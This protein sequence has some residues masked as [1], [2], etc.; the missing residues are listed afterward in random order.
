MGK[1]VELTEV[2]PDI[3]LYC[4][5]EHVVCLKEDGRRELWSTEDVS[6]LVVVVVVMGLYVVTRRRELCRSK[7]IVGPS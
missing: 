3:L 5:V 1:L 2:R 6:S 4:G 7:N